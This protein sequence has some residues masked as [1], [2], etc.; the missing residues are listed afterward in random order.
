MPPNSGN[1][2]ACHALEL[3]FVFDNFDKEGNKLLADTD[4]PQ[5]LAEAMYRAWVPFAT[6]GD[7]GWPQ[8]DPAQRATMRFDR[9]QEVVNDPR[10]AERRLWEGLR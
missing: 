8:Y 9:T 2:G 5:Q 10:S 3:G 1:L 7:P 6:H 4:A